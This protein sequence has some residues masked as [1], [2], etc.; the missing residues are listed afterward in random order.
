MKTEGRIRAP[1][2]DDVSVYTGVLV[3]QGGFRSRASWRRGRMVEHDARLTF[4]PVVAIRAMIRMTAKR[5]QDA[6]REAKPLPRHADAEACG[7][8]SSGGRSQRGVGRRCF[9]TG[10]PVGW[11]AARTGGCCMGAARTGRGVAWVAAF[12]CGATAFTFRSAPAAG[13]E[14]HHRPIVG[15]G[16]SVDASS[17]GIRWASIVSGRSCQS[18]WSRMCSAI[19]SGS[20]WSRSGSSTPRRCAPR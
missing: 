6:D 9:C 20:R 8:P 15:E 14:K 17:R 12:P 2:G 19:R 7:G 1:G 3:D 18:S 11:G 16:A 13:A 5:K 4:Q 10:W